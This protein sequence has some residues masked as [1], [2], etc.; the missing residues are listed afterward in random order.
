MKSP[1][2]QDLESRDLVGPRKS[3]AAAAAT[4]ATTAVWNQET[5]LP[6]WQDP[7]TY[8][9]LPESSPW[10][11]SARSLLLIRHYGMTEWRLQAFYIIDYPKGPKVHL[12]RVKRHATE[13]LK[14]LYSDTFSKIM[15]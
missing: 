3:P 7:E 15:W 10:A 11:C 2:T 12:T 13:F 9:H 4:T 14:N 8:P 5:H 1:E 6:C